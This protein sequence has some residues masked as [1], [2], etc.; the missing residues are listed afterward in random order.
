MTASEARAAVVAEAKTWLLTPYHHQARVKGAG[1][2]C[3]MILIE[4]YSA[5]GLIKNFDPGFYV[6]DWMLHRSE[7]RYLG[8]V[9]QYAHAVD[10]PKPGD[11]A[12]YQFGRCVSHG[13]IVIDWPTIIH[14][15]A[16]EGN[17]CL[18]DG[19][20]GPLGA[21]LRGFYSLIGDS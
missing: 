15:Y 4:V 9:Q 5:V 19:T 8:W 1:V 17:V 10:E 12:L 16:P 2:D 3:A 18:G 14:A 11:I 6:T 21:R 20:A 13:A 7:E